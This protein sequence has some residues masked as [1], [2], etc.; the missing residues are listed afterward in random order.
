MKYKTPTLEPAG[1]ASELIQ[2]KQEPVGDDLQ[3][4]SHFTM[5]AALETE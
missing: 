5:C 4:D 3:Q 2:I 1:K